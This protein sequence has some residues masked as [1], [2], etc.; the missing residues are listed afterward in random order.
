MSEL[1]TKN[2]LVLSRG[3]GGKLLAQ[4]VVLE[5][6]EDKPIVKVYPLTRGKLQEIYQKANSSDINEKMAS[7]NEILKF[8]LASPELTDEEIKDIKPNLATAITQAILSVSLG[9][10]QEEIKKKAEEV[11]AN[12]EIELLKK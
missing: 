12:Q 9:V 2:K 3:E 7:D 8:G 10:S 4:E 5:G 1:L 11:I 6:V